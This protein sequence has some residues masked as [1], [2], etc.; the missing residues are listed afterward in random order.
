MEAAG[1]FYICDLDD[2]KE[3]V[4]NACT[5]VN[6]CA[7]LCPGVKDEPIHCRCLR[8]ECI[9]D[10][11]L[12]GDDFCTICYIEP[13]NAAPCVDLPCGH[14]F[15]YQCVVEKLENGPASDYLSYQFADCPLC[16]KPIEHPV[17]EHLLGPI[18]VQQELVRKL[19]RRRLEIDG[20]ED[21]EDLQPGKPFH[22]D[23]DGYAEHI[24]SFYECFQCKKPYFGG[25]KRC[26]DGLGND[27]D[28]QPPNIEKKAELQRCAAC[29][30]LNA[31]CG[32]HGN[33]FIEFKCRFCCSLATFFCGGKCHYCTPCHDMAGTLTNFSDWSTKWDCGKINDCA[34][35]DKCPLKV[36]HPKN[37]EEYALGCAACRA[38]R[39]KA[40]EERKKA[41]KNKNHNNNNN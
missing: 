18:R 34:G 37:G 13:L 5:H 7:H 23:P 15:H 30:G 27:D 40:I 39:E 31:T 8:E 11:D 2:C 4:K 16:K 29:S 3:K 9:E 20:R 10:N 14:L 19:A 33:D 35:I 17:L 24:Y 41:M 25:E 38:D 12:D 32:I 22:N 6:P 1:E 26:A 28:D 21:D 36:D